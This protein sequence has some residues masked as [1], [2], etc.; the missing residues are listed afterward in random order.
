[1]PSSPVSLIKG[2]KAVTVRLC[3][4]NNHSII[5][6]PDGGE[7]SSSNEDVAKAS[8]T[9]ER[10]VR[11]TSVDEG[12]CEI[13]YKKDDLSTVLPIIVSAEPL[14]ATQVDFETGDAVFE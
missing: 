12:T 5:P 6:V 9:K 13:I 4:R 7:L 2:G 8:F 1:M 10:Y 11:I 3:F 14:D